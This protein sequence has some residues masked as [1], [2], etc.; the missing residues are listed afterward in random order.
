MTNTKFYDITDVCKMLH[1]T[2]RTLRFYEEKGIITSTTIGTSTRRQYT[3]EQVNHIRNVLVLRTLG[4]SVK[5]ISQLQQEHCDLK[6]AILAKRTEI[7]ASIEAKRK[8]I[9]LLNDALVLLK[10]EKNIF[11]YNWS[12]TL[13]SNYSDCDAIARECTNNIIRGNHKLL[14]AHFSDK[15][16]SYLPL[17]A[18]QKVHTDTLIPLGNFVVFEKSEIDSQNSN[19]IFH[20]VQYEKAGLRIQYIFH[21]NELHGLWFRYYET[22]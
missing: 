18:Y 7:Y 14:Y 5:S 8:E 3:K 13:P 10:E 19:V 2:S 22:N 17:E 15:L 11:D 16:K 20:Y 4:L 12:N 6:N 9:H 1:T 21:N